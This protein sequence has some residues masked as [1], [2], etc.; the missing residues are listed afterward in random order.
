M[1]E[2]V[3]C[4]VSPSASC[5]VRRVTVIVAFLGTSLL[6][7][8]RAE[9]GSADLAVYRESIAK[10]N[11][12]H[13]AK[14]GDVDE[15]ALGRKLPK[16]ASAALD[17][18]LA[19]DRVVASDLIAAGESA[20]DL[21]RMDDFERVRARLVRLAPDEATK[22]GIAV[23]RPRFLL[24]GVDGLEAPALESMAGT[25]DLVLDA[26]A[27]VFGF[28]TWSKVPGKK[29]R[30]RARLVER[31]ERPPHFA[32][33]FP[34][35]SEIDFPVVAK[36][37]FRSP[38]ADGKFLFYGLCHELGHVRAMW[39]DV[40][41]EADHHAW[42]HYTGAVIVEHLAGAAEHADALRELRDAKW[43]TWTIELA[44]LDERKARPG[45]TDRDS[46]SAL[47]GALHGELGPRALGDALASVD[48]AGKTRR[49]NHV[50]YY[51]LADFEAAL[52]ATPAGKKSAKRIAAWFDGER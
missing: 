23:S 47:L 11:D 18:L 2:T 16:F 27:D 30:V 4:R 9:P 5:V 45:T 24:R 10:L 26:Y 3:E 52:V 43:R 14:P 51:V 25:L 50:R 49:V 36:D 32:P 21:D 29:L 31:I 33:Q 13:V 15:A 6:A 37:A 46:V 7:S 8:A 41:D 48:R 39:G 35:H 28:T 20:L 42:A 38:T 40:K 22:L 44:E 34:W 19:D 12:A 1:S 17:R